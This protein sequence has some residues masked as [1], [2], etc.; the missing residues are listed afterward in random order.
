M[1]NKKYSNKNY[2]CEDNGSKVKRGSKNKE[3]QQK[4]K[5]APVI[6]SQGLSYH[7]GTSSDS[8]VTY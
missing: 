4:T 7:R 1:N 2:T 3:K 5:D 6:D 8:K